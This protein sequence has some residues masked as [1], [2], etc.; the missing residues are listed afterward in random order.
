MQNYSRAAGQSYAS[1]LK[2]FRAR[3]S[4]SDATQRPSPAT[5][6]AVA[7]VAFHFAGENAEM[8]QRNTS[9]Q[10]FHSGSEL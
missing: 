4:G 7:V 8:L 9:D 5:G 6:A 3:Q 1:H 10:R 2:T